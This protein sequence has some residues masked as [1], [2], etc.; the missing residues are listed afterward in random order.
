[1]LAGMVDS[2]DAIRYHLRT[3]DD[4]NISVQKEQHTAEQLAKYVDKKSGENSLRVIEK[5]LEVC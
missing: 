1:L 2:V 5:F 4:L 3:L